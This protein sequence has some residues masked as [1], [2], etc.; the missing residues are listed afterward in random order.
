MKPKRKPTKVEWDATAQ[1][2]VELKMT[3][4]QWFAVAA[5]LMLLAKQYLEKQ[6]LPEAQGLMDLSE[7]IQKLTG[8]AS[9]NQ[10]PEEES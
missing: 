3:R 5:G 10:A 9:L 2:I 1:E 8:C 4:G 6:A 7:Q